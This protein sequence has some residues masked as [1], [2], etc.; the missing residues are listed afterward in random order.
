MLTA[1]TARAANRLLGALLVALSVTL[2]VND[3]I[4]FGQQPLPDEGTQAHIFQLSVAA[5]VP[6]IA[7]FAA[8]LDRSRSPRAAWPLAFA[9][10][11][12]IEHH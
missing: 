2:L 4:G 8:T 6:A 3:A 11:Y 7:L 12:Y 10:V 5:I 9:G 1:M